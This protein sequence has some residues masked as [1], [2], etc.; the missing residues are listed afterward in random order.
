M[1]VA[2]SISKHAHVLQLGQIVLKGLREELLA[3]E[4][5]KSIYLGET[6]LQ[7]HSY[8]ILFDTSSTM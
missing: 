8:R 1:E 5:V 6:K 4:S 7:R 2:L 3:D